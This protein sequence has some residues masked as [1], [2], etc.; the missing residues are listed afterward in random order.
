MNFNKK[1]YVSLIK[2]Y[3]LSGFLLF[4]NSRKNLIELTS[5]TGFI[6]PLK[7]PQNSKRC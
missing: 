3:E 2:I 6:T 5:K 4:Q 1:K 7:L